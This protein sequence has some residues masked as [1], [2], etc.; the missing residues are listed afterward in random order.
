MVVQNSVNAKQLTL[1]NGTNFRNEN[2]NSQE[3]NKRLR[4]ANYGL[5]AIFNADSSFEQKLPHQ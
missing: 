1:N 4:P 2:P 5:C 3:A